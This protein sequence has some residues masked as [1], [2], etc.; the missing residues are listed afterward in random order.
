MPNHMYNV[1]RMSG[2]GHTID[3]ILESIKTKDNCIDF[4]KIVSIP[5]DIKEWYQEEDNWY[6]WNL[7]HW[8]TKW[9]SFDSELINNSLIRFTTAY[10]P[11]LP[12]IAKLSKLF[13]TVEFTLIYFEEINDIQ[14]IIVY[15]N[16]KR[17][18]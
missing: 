13:K 5:D 8:G 15:K 11:P 4:D 12:V 16:G 10:T 6:G 9:N 3:L 17:K 18:T 7:E 14:N 1:L 2:K